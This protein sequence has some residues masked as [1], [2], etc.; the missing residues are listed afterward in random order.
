MAG[1]RSF[2]PEACRTAQ[3]QGLTLYA[4]DTGNDGEDDTLIAYH[5]ESLTEITQIILDHH[6]RATWPAHWS[7]DRVD[8]P[9]NPT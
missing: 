6:E 3:D 1:F 5:H 7:L 2:T 4:L 8:W 9:I